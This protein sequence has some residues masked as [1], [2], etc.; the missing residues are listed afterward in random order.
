M[1]LESSK[2]IL[3]IILSVAGVIRLWGLGELG[4]GFFRDEAALGYNIYSM[5]L[6]GKDEFAK[7]FPIIFRSFEVFFLP[8]YVYLSVPIVWVL[9][10]SVF[11]TR[12]LSAIAGVVAV[13]GVYYLAGVLPA[14]LLAT[15]AWHIFFSRGTFEG[16]LALTVFLLGV[17][18]WVKYLKDRKLK[19]LSISLLTTVISMY[20]YQS[21]RLVVPLWWMCNL[22]IYKKDLPRKFVEWFKVLLF[23]VLLGLPLLFI[24]FSPAGLHRA[25]GVSLFSANANTSKSI[26]NLVWKISAMYSH[27]FSPKNL[28]WEGDYDKQR[29]LLGLSVFYWWWIVGWV[30]G[31]ILVF[32]NKVK[33]WWLVSWWILSPIPAALTPDTFHTYRSLMFYIP[34]TIIIGLGFRDLIRSKISKILFLFAS[35]FSLVQ[36]FSTYVYLTPMVRAKD[37]DQPFKETAAKV[38]SLLKTEKKIVWDRRI[39]EPYIQYLFWSGYDPVKLQEVT[40]NLEFDYYGSVGEVRFSHLDK[41]YFEPINWGARKREVGTVFVVDAADTPESSIITDERLKIIDRISLPD[42]RRFFNIVKVIN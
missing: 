2:K 9:G 27:Y 16:N 14:I 23:P 30:N 5:A 4:M 13:G 37:W 33:D 6:T 34:N 38:N 41:L 28:F 18:F 12:L 32:K 8:L 24:W 7:S 20:G 1:P 31:I 26:T 29:S 3:L 10:L 25:Q 42:G 21:E 39:S 40:K 19:Y 11:S 17:C 22:A 36:L 35:V 15:S